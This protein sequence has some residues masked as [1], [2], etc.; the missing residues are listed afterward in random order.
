[1]HPTEN[2]QASLPS[3][4]AIHNFYDA[5]SALESWGNAELEHAR[6]EAR[7]RSIEEISAGLEAISN[8]V[9]DAGA[10]I[11]TAKH[12]AAS[13]RQVLRDAADEDSMVEVGAVDRPMRGDV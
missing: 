2:T 9:K 5:A 3:L 8:F 11:E 13:L 7:G 4:A 10:R 1:M 12:I 6:R